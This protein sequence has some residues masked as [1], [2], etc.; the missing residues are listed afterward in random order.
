MSTLEIVLGKCRKNAKHLFHE[1]APL[2][3]TLSPEDFVEFVGVKLFVLRWSA[4]W[5]SEVATKY[6]ELLLKSNYSREIVLNYFEKNEYCN[7]NVTAIIWKNQPRT[8]AYF[9]KIQKAFNLPAH[10]LALKKAIQVN[11]RFGINLV[12][13]VEFISHNLETWT[14]KQRFYENIVKMYSVE[15]LLLHITSYYVDYKRNSSYHINNRKLLNDVRYNL[16]LV[17]N[18]WLRVKR[19]QSSNPDESIF[20]NAT[21]KDLAYRWSEICPPENTPDAVLD[22][23]KRPALNLSPEVKLLRECVEFYLQHMRQE[24]H[25][26]LY[27]AGHAEFLF[28]DSEYQEAEIETNGHKGVYDNNDRKYSYEQQFLFRQTVPEHVQDDP[29]N[30]IKWWG[31]RNG[32]GETSLAWW[33]FHRLPGSIINTAAQ[34]DMIKVLELLN[35]LSFNLIPPGRIIFRNSDDEVVAGPDREENSRFNNWFPK[36][37]NILL[38]SRE[39]LSSAIIGYFEWSKGEVESIL[40]FLTVDLEK[41][42]APLPDILERPFIETPNGLLW[43]GDFYKSMA[44]Y[45]TQSNHLKA[46]NIASEVDGNPYHILQSKELENDLANWFRGSGFEAINSR[47]YKRSTG[48]EGEIDVI[49]MK[50]NI[51]FIVE[52]KNSIRSVRYLQSHKKDLQRYSIEAA[53][54][55][56]EIEDFV[57]DE[58]KRFTQITGVNV[59]SGTQIV[60]LIVSLSFDNDDTLQGDG[61]LKISLFELYILLT[62]QVEILYEPI[63][64][65]SASVIEAMMNS[66]QPFFNG[67][68]ISNSPEQPLWEGNLSGPQLYELIEK[69]SVWQPLKK[70]WKFIPER[71]TLKNFDPSVRLLS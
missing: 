20:D 51:L 39:A 6:V 3:L 35:V 17:I 66:N 34:V 29:Q 22:S 27:L 23:S 7:E 24:Y 56:R 10:L 61:I 14:G 18:R 31:S 44:W 5:Q 9:F 54:Q 28:L 33:K 62:S 12:K 8:C 43:L 63:K 67:D 49:A 60:P 30:L 55:L 48:T 37:D 4:F 21:S 45:Y 26:E 42:E 52:I 58:P 16:I 47:K 65:V 46:E 32:E 68:S 19:N 1:I 38:L 50:D 2:L 64:G 13:E 57:R 71:T 40:Q 41:V 69:D 70:Q 11:D 59:R 25:S 36:S 15:E 53:A